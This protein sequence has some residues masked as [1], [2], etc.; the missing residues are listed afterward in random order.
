[1]NST[2]IRKL[3]TI[4]HRSNF[5]KHRKRS[6]IPESQLVVGTNSQRALNVGLSLEEN[7]ITNL[8]YTVRPLLISLKL[9]TQ[10]SSQQMLPQQTRYYCPLLQPFI[11]IRNDS[12]RNITDT[13]MPRLIPIQYF[14]RW[15]IQRRMVSSIVPK[16]YQSKPSKPF[17]GAHVHKTTEESLQ[18]LINSIRLSIGL[19]IV[20]RTHLE[21]SISQTEQLS[22]QDTREYTVS[23]R[24]NVLWHAMKFV[25]ITQISHS[26]M[27]H[28]ER[29]GQSHKMSI[30]TELVHHYR[31]TIK[32][33]WSRQTLNKVKS[34]S[35]PS[36]LKN[37]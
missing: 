3:Q 1:M 8:K 7:P 30:L 21:L 5:L 33:R 25:D 9:H 4:S 20:W 18:T 17:L 29:M 28:R 6:K 15:L 10:L 34:N 31:N 36:I 12:F 14:K 35:L 23:I 19:R 2:I 37:W 11:Q 16:L 22:P 13:K 26:H 32:P 27:K 24:N